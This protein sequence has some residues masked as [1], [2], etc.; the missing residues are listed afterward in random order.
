[1]GFI[2]AIKSHTMNQCDEFDGSDCI[3]SYSSSM[4]LL[5]GYENYTH[6]VTFE[7]MCVSSVTILSS[8]E[9]NF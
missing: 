2:M 1:M 9:N 7:C 8:P 5:L 4:W 3:L 6:S